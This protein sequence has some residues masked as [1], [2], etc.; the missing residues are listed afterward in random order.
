[1]SRQNK[2]YLTIIAVASGIILLSV[3]AALIG[4]NDVVTMEIQKGERYFEQGDYD[5]ALLAY[6]RAIDKNDADAEAYLGMVRVYEKTGDWELLLKTLQTGLEK[7]GDPRIR[8]ML[9]IYLTQEE[10]VAA[11]D[12]AASEE[13][14]PE[15]K[16]EAGTRERRAGRGRR[17][18]VRC[19]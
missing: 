5:R 16:R 17:G 15:R 7:T 4:F 14:V 6:Q 11:Q 3:S 13:P 19:I 9:S 1:M 18:G 12:L 2:L 8:A 10:A